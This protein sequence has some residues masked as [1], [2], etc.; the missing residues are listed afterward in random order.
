MGINEFSSFGRRGSGF[1]E[2]NGESPPFPW[3]P[4]LWVLMIESCRRFVQSMQAKAFSGSLTAGGN[5][6]KVLCRTCFWICPLSRKFLEIMYPVVPRLSC[7]RGTVLEPVSLD[8]GHA[9]S[10]DLETAAL[11]MSAD[12]NRTEIPSSVSSKALLYESLKPSIW[13]VSYAFANLMSPPSTHSP[14][15]AFLVKSSNLEG[16]TLTE[17][18][19]ESVESVVMLLQKDDFKDLKTL[20]KMETIIQLLQTIPNQEHCSSKWCNRRVAIQCVDFSKQTIIRDV[21]RLLDSIA[22]SLASQQKK[23]SVSLKEVSPSLSWLSSCNIP[24]PGLAIEASRYGI[25]SVH[26]KVPEIVLLSWLTQTMEA[27]LWLT[28]NF[29]DVAAIVSSSLFSSRVKEIRIR[30][31]EHHDLLLA[32]LPAVVFVAEVR[33]SVVPEATQAHRNSSYTE[34]SFLELATSVKASP[35]LG[36]H[37]LCKEHYF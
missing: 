14:F 11:K 21:W 28:G 10:L 19:A 1:Q 32:M 24:M 25:L 23:S 8:A 34:V 16:F 17:D 30:L 15:Q 22:V 26:N 18:E 29:H 36:R 7:A 9:I 35:L 3:I 13:W 27:A 4:A 33:L 2:H 6:A 12:L 31:Q 20:G 5:Q 37:L